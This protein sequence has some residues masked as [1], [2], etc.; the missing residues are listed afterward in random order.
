LS[1]AVIDQRLR[2][3]TQSKIILP[4]QVAEHQMKAVLALVCMNAELKS[5]IAGVPATY[6]PCSPK[7]VIPPQRKSAALL[8]LKSSGFQFVTEHERVI[9]WKTERRSICL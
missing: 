4:T 1:L 6:M 9:F 3:N 2:V 7:S 5:A 8:I